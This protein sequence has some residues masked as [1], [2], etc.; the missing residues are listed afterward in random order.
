MLLWTAHTSEIV[1]AEIRHERCGELDK[2]DTQRVPVLLLNNVLFVE[3]NELAFLLTITL[4]HPL[5]A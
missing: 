2:H 5:A 1:G 4:S 3:G